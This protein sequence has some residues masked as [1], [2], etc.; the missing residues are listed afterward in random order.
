MAL[1]DYSV[2]ALEVALGHVTA[3]PQAHKAQQAEVQ[4][5]RFMTALQ[6]DL[7]AASKRERDLSAQRRKLLQEVGV[8]LF[9]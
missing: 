4:Q 8:H 2:A 5:Q 7:S 3:G 9:C 1:F 6:R